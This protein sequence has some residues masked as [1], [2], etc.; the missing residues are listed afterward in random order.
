MSSHLFE[1]QKLIGGRIWYLSE[2]KTVGKAS[3]VEVDPRMYHMIWDGF[4]ISEAAGWLFVSSDNWSARSGLGVKGTA[5]F[6][7]R[8]RFRLNDRVFWCGARRGR[9]MVEE[10]LSEEMFQTPITTPS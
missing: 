7:R 5:D 10:E 3:P 8:N 9:E 4:Q 1:L 6:L 2:F